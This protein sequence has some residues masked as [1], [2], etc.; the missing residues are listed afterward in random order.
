M[1]INTFPSLKEPEHVEYHPTSL[2]V[3]NYHDSL[4]DSVNILMDFEAENYISFSLDHPTHKRHP[5]EHSAVATD[6]WYLKEF[7]GQ[8]KYRISADLK[9]L[10]PNQSN[11]QFP[12]KISC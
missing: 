3:A 9:T 6:V 12:I 7:W 1:I 4:H 10:Q 8:Q 2:S 5:T 11:G